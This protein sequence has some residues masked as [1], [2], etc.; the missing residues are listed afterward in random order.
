MGKV[1]VRE[2]WQPPPHVPN[3]GGG[4]PGRQA[5]HARRRQLL[6]A[7]DKGHVLDQVLVGTRQG[8]EALAPHELGQ[9]QVGAGREPDPNG[10]GGAEG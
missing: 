6:E 1:Q 8:V 4:E 5:F 2:T 7:R 10:W 3:R 9:Q